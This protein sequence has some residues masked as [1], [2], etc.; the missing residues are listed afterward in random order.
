MY[1][2]IYIYIDIWMCI[3]ATKMDIVSINHNHKDLFLTQVYDDEQKIITVELIVY[4]FIV[5]L[6]NKHYLYQPLRIFFYSEGLWFK[7]KRHS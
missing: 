1:I 2:Y 6:S 3:V 7:Q 5:L 4:K